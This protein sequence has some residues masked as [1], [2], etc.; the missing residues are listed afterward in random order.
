MDQTKTELLRELNIQEGILI[1]SR[2]HMKEDFDFWFKVS[3]G[4][5]M[6][7]LRTQ[8]Q[9]TDYD[10]AC[11]ISDKIADIDAQL[12]IIREKQLTCR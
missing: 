3:G 5:M 7:M 4:D 8:M 10:K 2:R 6:P 11:E 9:R 12:R 1:N